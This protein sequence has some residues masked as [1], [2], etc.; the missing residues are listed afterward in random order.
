M[1]DLLQVGYSVDTSGLS[2]GGNALSQ[3]RQQNAEVQKSVDAVSASVNNA[4]NATQAYA[5]K[6]AAAN[7][8]MGSGL[9]QTVNNYVRDL[10][11]ASQAMAQ[12]SQTAGQLGTTYTGLTNTFQ[13]LGGGFS[14]LINYFKQ[15]GTATAETTSQ[16]R[17]G[18]AAYNEHASSITS[19]RTA[20]AAMHLLLGP[21]GAQFGEVTAAVH[22][23]HAGMTAFAALVGAAVVVEMAKLASEAD[24]LVKHLGAL[25]GNS[26]SAQQAMESLRQ[27]ASATGV[28]MG[29]LTKALESAAF[30]AG[31]GNW[32]GQKQAIDS[33]RDSVVNLIDAQQK[34]NSLRM[35]GSI[36]QANY[37]SAV[38][39]AEM[40]RVEAQIKA[41]NAS[42]PAES[43]AAARDLASAETD[44]EIATTKAAGAQAELRGQMALAQVEM[45][46]AQ[47]EADKATNI[48]SAL[49]EQSRQPVSLDN[50]AAGLDTLTKSAKLQ[51]ATAAQVQKDYDTLFGGLQKDGYMTLQTFEGLSPRMQQALAQMFKGGDTVQD[52][53]NLGKDIDNGLAVTISELLKKL[54]QAKDDINQ[55]FSD[56]PKDVGTALERLK[57]VA[58]NALEQLAEGAGFKSLGDAID[59]LATAL[60]NLVDQDYF[61]QLGRQID[62]LLSSWDRL[63]ST[64][65]GALIGGRL[66]GAPGAAVG[67]VLGDKLGQQIDAIKKQLDEMQAQQNQQQQEQQ[68]QQ[69]EQQQQ[70]DQNRQPVDVDA[71]QR[72][73]DALGGGAGLDPSQA[74]SLLGG[75][76]GGGAGGALVGGPM[77]ALVGA[78]LGGI[79]ASIPNKAGASETNDQSTLLQEQGQTLDQIQQGIDKSTDGLDKLQ[80][81]LE[82][83]GQ[84]YQNDPQQQTA[85]QTL[86][87]ISQGIS[88]GNQIDSQAAQADAQNQDGPILREALSSAAQEMID[89]MNQ[90]CQ[91]TVDTING[92]SDNVGNA[93]KDITDAIGNAAQSIVSAIG[94]IQINVN[95]G[96]GGGGGSSSSG[97]GGGDS[98]SY[99]GGDSSYS[100]G[101]SSDYSGDSGGDYYSSDDF[102]GYAAGGSFTVRGSGGIDSKLVQ[103]WATPGEKVSVSHPGAPAFG[104][105]T[106][107][108]GLMAF[109][110]GGT[111]VVA[112]DTGPADLSDARA[113]NV[114]VTA[115]VPGAGTDQTMTDALNAITTTIANADED[116]VN[117]IGSVGDDLSNRLQAIFDQIK[118]GGGTGNG[119]GTGTSATDK[120]KQ[121]AAGGGSTTGTSGGA[122]VDV[123]QWRQMEQEDENAKKQAAQQKAQQ[124]KE[125]QQ[126]AQKQADEQ[127]KQEKAAAQERQRAAAQAQQDEDR[128][129]NAYLDTL[130]KQ[131]KAA[132]DTQKA[133]QQ[134]IANDLKLPADK[135]QAAFDQLYAKQGGQPLGYQQDANGQMQP[136][137]RQPGMEWQYDPKT[138]TFS[139]HPNQDMQ[140]GL[141]IANKEGA[142]EGQSLTEKQIDDIM[143]QQG[144]RDRSQGAEQAGGELMQQLEKNL[145]GNP[146]QP[147][148]VKLEGQTQQDL[149]RQAENTQ[150]MSQGIDKQTE[151]TDQMSK[152][153]DDQTT[154]TNE[155]T[156]INKDELGES[157]KQSDLINGTNDGIMG[158]DDTTGQGFKDLGG[159][160]SN[161][162]DA[163][164]K[165]IESLGAAISQAAS[166]NNGGNQGSNSFG[167]SSNG[168]FSNGFSNGSNNGFDTGDFS[169]GDNSDGGVNFDPG[170]FDTG[171]FSSGNNS[172]GGVNFD[173]GGFDT[174]DF[175]GN[176]GDSGFSG[177]S[178]G[179]FDTADFSGGGGDEAFATGGAFTVKG[180]GGTDSQL[181]KFWA[182]P[183][184]KVTVTPPGVDPSAVEGNIPYKKSGVN[185]FATGGI[186][187]RGLDPNTDYPT[188]GSANGSGVPLV[189]GSYA[190]SLPNTFGLYDKDQQYGMVPYSFGGGGGFFL[191]PVTY[192][193]PEDTSALGPY[194]NAKSLGDLNGGLS[195]GDQMAAT[196]AGQQS[197]GDQSLNLDAARQSIGD[198][199]QGLSLGDQMKSAG[200]LLH[201][202][203][204]QAA[205]QI[206]APNN[207]YAA[208]AALATGNGQSLDEQ[209]A[210]LQKA[211]GGPVQAA[212]GAS[213]L[214]GGRGGT[215]SQHVHI[216][217]TPGERV[218]VTPPGVSHDNVPDYGTYDG[219]RGFANGGTFL[220]DGPGPAD[221]SE[222]AKPVS[223]TPVA[224][225]TRLINV[226]VTINTKDLKSFEQSE[227]QVKEQM[228]RAVAEA[229]AW[230]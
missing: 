187:A 66:A 119:T 68:Q 139:Q 211:A 13:R 120:T 225:P 11:N 149:Q 99:G 113:A 202:D 153:I 186:A 205:Q 25:V 176:G 173:P 9:G 227:A 19:S 128:S 129:Y 223:A 17:L 20:L 181:V 213:F 38:D 86:D 219:P 117:K 158:L 203:Y 168:G 190:N 208:A 198:A 21:L 228:Q 59:H 143:G 1:A 122:Y 193:E 115:T 10:N 85:N 47:Q 112:P 56:M 212:S 142:N 82:Q 61:G 70:P 137:Y 116:I 132:S 32:S 194:A 110:D 230:K 207:D 224:Q 157:Q 204:S 92:V 217:A 33:Y 106:V 199:Y 170:G 60:Q 15:T 159:S 172:D 71:T 141:N 164:V 180:A 50:L 22:L 178:S 36:N 84:I 196:G 131:Q 188:S 34:L 229:E 53:I 152:G 154:A 111:A 45:Q 206:V 8:Q 72:G 81:G 156:G 51:G 165:A 93:D 210:E 125:E 87:S 222:V 75:V 46:K 169:N 79:F 91:S 42:N 100:D 57:T 49:A 166:G 62:G 29:T 146:N 95:T 39:D 103:F 147:Q 118:A 41:Q 127:A 88:Q 63:A 26:A 160:V 144:M 191:V 150:Q 40:K 6:L 162:G 67:A 108:G 3:F 30:A 77:G 179:G 216:M 64:G 200:D 96:G 105:G 148:E 104:R 28:D 197:Y 80:G 73:F 175:S 14:G 2:Q 130:N 138:N 58:N 97:G 55:R 102:A 107:K 7:Q 185:A 226:Q 35:Q 23:L 65:L 16:V 135:Q 52:I 27:T 161:V 12:H 192:D 90:C 155:Q 98:G 126:Q 218:T 201:P 44:M 4:G 54:D 124:Q 174:G 163:I 184:E 195:L 182:S 121:P 5:A 109:A 89:A 209:I 31:G 18:T 134:E 94:N 140:A 151:S 220:V 215:D 69:Q 177:L 76:L 83:L 101:G 48:Y 123:A 167:N 145:F 136:F 214:V 133:I 24:E 171:D 183:G 78:I 189:S 37:N 114:G 221:R 74:F 43:I